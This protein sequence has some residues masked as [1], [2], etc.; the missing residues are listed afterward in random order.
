MCSSDLAKYQHH[1]AQAL[2][3]IAGTEFLARS[4]R[5]LDHDFSGALEHGV[6]SLAEHVSP[7]EKS[8]AFEDLMG[9]MLF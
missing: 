9:K 6:T 1:A 3:P 5:A 4:G 8:L 7:H 2:R